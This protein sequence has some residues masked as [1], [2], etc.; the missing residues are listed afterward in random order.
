[1]SKAK[2]AKQQFSQP[3]LDW[4][5][6]FGRHDLPWQQD[7]NPYRVWVSEIM[8]QQTQVTT[9]IPY[10]E[11]FMQSFPDVQ[12]LADA[13]QEEVLSHWAGL[14]YYA[15]GRNLH[16]AALQIVDLHNAEFPQ[17]FDEIVALPG[18]GRS[19]AGAI[20]SIAL[21]Q[22]F[23]ILDGNVK[24]VLSRYY[25]IEG[26]PGE[27]SIESQMWLLADELTP[28]QRFNDYTQAIMDLG[29]TLCKRSKPDCETCPVKQT[30]QAFAKNEVERFPFKKP[31]KEKPIKQAWLLIKQSHTGEILLYKRPQKGIWGGLWSLPEY[32]S[33]LAC[34]ESLQSQAISTESLIEWESFRH[35]FS[36]YHLDITP[37]YLQ[38]AE[39]KM[40]LPHTEAGKV[41][42][43]F[44]PYQSQELQWVAITNIV[45]GDLGVP[46]PVSKMVEKIK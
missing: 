36:H 42:E 28:E 16:K 14:G 25:A 17:N 19:T 34:C 44:A 23:A 5:D 39:P 26:W 1:M 29:A 37:L 24:R 41:A 43:Q 20:L 9:V 8:L 27:K 4:F 2:T 22:R 11:R 21:G 3:L 15:R 35:T 33:Y 46:A 13:S 30:C 12:S 32:D 38:L 10:F 7:I 31:K 45:N 18:I 6:Q 40:S